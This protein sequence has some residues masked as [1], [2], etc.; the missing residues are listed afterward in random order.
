MKEC[1]LQVY[2]E[3][4]FLMTVKF[5]IMALTHSQNKLSMHSNVL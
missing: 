3:A 2:P 5:F 1:H 4:R